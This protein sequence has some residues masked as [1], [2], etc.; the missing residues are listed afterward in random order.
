MN[1]DITI[2]INKKLFGGLVLL[3]IV[4]AIPLTVYISQQ[5]Q[6]TQQNAAVFSATHDSCKLITVSAQ[7]SPSCPRLTQS[8]NGNNTCTIPDRSKKNPNI[9]DYTYI[10]AL[11]SNDGKP[12]TVKYKYVTNF[13]THGYGDFYGSTKDCHCNSNT[14]S[15]GDQVLTI[16]ASGSKTL[17]LHR[18]PIQGYANCGAY[19]FDVTIESID[20]RSSCT[21]TPNQLGNTLSVGHCDTGIDCTAVTPTPPPATVQPTPTP[22]PLPS[23]IPSPSVCVTPGKVS[24]VRVICPACTTPTI[25]P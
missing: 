6:Q 19:Q 5:R 3:L 7:E 12:H 8:S 13:C 20:G 22:T 15:S 11:S 9:S 21:L 14:Q 16:N 18:S 10:V 2:K 25:T 24:N 17:T 4:A 23:T 1:T